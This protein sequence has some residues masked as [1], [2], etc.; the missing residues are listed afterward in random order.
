MAFQQPGLFPWMTVERNVTIGL[1]VRGKNKKE[2]KAIAHDFLETVGLSEFLKAYPSQL[3]GGMAQRVG[4][5]RALALK[6]RLLLL[7]EP[8]ASVDAFTRIKLQAELRK[9]LRIVGPTVVLVTHDVSEAISLGDTVIVMSN[10][11]ATVK[12]VVPIEASD[13]DKGSPSYATKLARI[14]EDLGVTEDGE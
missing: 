13:K 11:P 10:R 14:L 9:M 7:D 6:P 3:S 4:I 2:A 1:E 8:F 5:A 12:S